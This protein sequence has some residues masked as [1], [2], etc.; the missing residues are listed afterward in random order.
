[1]RVRRSVYLTL[2]RGR[3][4][5]RNIIALCMRPIYMLTVRVASSEGGW[6]EKRGKV[7]LR[8]SGFSARFRLSV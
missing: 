3:R 2:T 8:R 6:S 4:V 5:A 1:M 7:T